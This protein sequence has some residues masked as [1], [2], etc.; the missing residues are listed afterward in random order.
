MC[1]R[2]ELHRQLRRRLSNYK[3][4]TRIS[5]IYADLTA[6]HQRV[7][8]TPRHCSPGA[9]DYHSDPQG[10]FF[11]MGQCFF[12]KLAHHHQRSTFAPFDRDTFDSLFGDR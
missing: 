3:I 6:M 8:Q 9:E 11:R 5:Y 7:D 10:E 12:G 1:A 4:F 2:G